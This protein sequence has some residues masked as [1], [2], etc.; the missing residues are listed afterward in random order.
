MASRT[1]A[2]SAAKVAVLSPRANLLVILAALLLAGCGGDTPAPS[3]TP[4]PE[5]DAGDEDGNRPELHF[6]VTAK[7]VEPSR[8]EVPAFLGL[9]VRL[10]NRTGVVAPVTLDGESITQLPPGGESEVEVEGLRPGEHELRAGGGGRA[11]IVA[12]RAGG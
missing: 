5:Q 4:V 2:L 12:V 11:T 7:A 3:K 6:D 9:R 1:N 10:R 8:I